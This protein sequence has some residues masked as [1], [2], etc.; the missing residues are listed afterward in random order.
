MRA[1]ALAILLILPT[2]VS[3]EAAGRRHQKQYPVVNVKPRS[4]LN[5]GTEVPVGSLSRYVSDSVPASSLQ[6][7]PGRIGGDQPLPPRGGGIPIDFQ[8]P[9]FLTR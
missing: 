9:A 6:L 8:A 1:A 2:A 3:A 7:Y 4:F 5:A